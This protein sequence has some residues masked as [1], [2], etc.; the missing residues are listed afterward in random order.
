[1][2]ISNAHVALLFASEIITT[3]KNKFDMEN[4]TQNFEMTNHAIDRTIMR[5]ISIKDIETILMYGSTIHRQ[6]NKFHYIR[7]KDVPNHVGLNS[8]ITNI[9]VLTAL[10]GTVITCYYNDR[11]Q[12]HISK[13]HK[14]Y[15]KTKKNKSFQNGFSRNEIAKYLY[16]KI[17][18]A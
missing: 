1:M 16:G 15:S 9:V 3:T 11:P 14:R 13:K 2:C 17:N 12:K 6:S 7:E 18:L 8:R 10:D 4:L 5:N